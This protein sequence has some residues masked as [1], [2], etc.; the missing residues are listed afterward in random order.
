MEPPDA[1][2]RLYFLSLVEMLSNLE[3][4]GTFKPTESPTKSPSHAPSKSAIPSELPSPFPS[5]SPTQPPGTTRSPTKEPTLQDTEGLVQVPVEPVS[6]EWNYTY[7]EESCTSLNTS[8]RLPLFEEICANGERKLPTSVEG[9]D[10]NYAWLPVHD[11]EAEHSWVNIG[12]LNWYHV[13]SKY[14]VEDGEQVNPAKESPGFFYCFD[15]SSTGAPSESPSSAPSSGP[16]SQPS[17]I[18]SSKPSRF[19]SAQPSLEPSSQPTNADCSDLYVC[20]YNKDGSPKFPMCT[21]KDNKGEI[22]YESKCK[23]ASDVDG[24]I[25]DGR[26]LECGCCAESLEEDC[27]PP[28]TETR[29]LKDESFS[30]ESA[31]NSQ[32]KNQVNQKMSPK[33]QNNALEA[34]ESIMKQQEQ[35]HQQFQKQFMLMLVLIFGGFFLI[36]AAVV[37]GSFRATGRN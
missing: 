34:I 29:R 30:V 22:T 17:L 8:Y 5:A 16:T 13:C 18:P 14:V 15:K 25:A 24:L 36:M 19:P 11:I 12:T 33:I 31:E 6:L 37:W 4:K 32:S 20:G 35:F 2:K 10:E 28:V 3:H 21:I 27:P 7:A 26:F 9:I 23:R 1:H